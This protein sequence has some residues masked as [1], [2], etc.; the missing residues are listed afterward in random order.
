LTGGSLLKL[1]DFWRRFSGE[2]PPVKTPA[3]P[4]PD[5]A[6]VEDEIR[7][8]PEGS[9]TAARLYNRA[10]DLYLQCGDTSGALER[11]GRSIDSY[12]Q[13]G[14]YDHAIAV[15]RKVLRLVSGVVRARCTLAWLCIG[16]GFLD[17]AREEIEAYTHAAKETGHAA[18]AAQ[19]LRLMAR[20]VGGRS[21]REFVADRLEEL[22]D[23]TGAER[24]RATLD[25][26][27]E[28]IGWNP[29]VFAAL[30]SAEELRRAAEQGLEL[31]APRREDVI[32]RFMI[33][34]E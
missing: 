20:Y 34:P 26:P 33:Q 10:G 25:E 7:R 29:I 15:C 18:I 23:V 30:L 4:A 21:F 17:I 13:L 31:E 28:A 5:I 8:L 22:G 9:M 24:T 16:K 6:R 11:Y 3:V 19:Q 1:K 14:E 32:D 27:A 12:M 2:R